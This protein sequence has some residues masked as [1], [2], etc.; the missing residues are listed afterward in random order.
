MDEGLSLE[1]EIFI[2]YA[3]RGESFVDRLDQTFQAQEIRIIRDERDL[4]YKGQIRAF[5]EQ[6]DREKYAIE[7]MA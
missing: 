2:S 1:R 6:I 5:M 4:K 7:G 3:W